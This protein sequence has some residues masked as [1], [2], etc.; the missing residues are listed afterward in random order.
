M[1]EPAKTGFKS[2]DTFL[3]HL[4]DI[5]I[6][7]G[8]LIIGQRFEPFRDPGTP[9]EN[10]IVE[11]QA[12]KQLAATSI[13][14]SFSSVQ[15]FFNLFGSFGIVERIVRE[16]EA[17]AK[18]LSSEDNLKSGILR[19]RAYE[20]AA[21]IKEKAL[22]TGDYFHVTMLDSAG[23][24][25]GLRA[26][27][28]AEIDDST[29]SAWQACLGAAFEEVFADSLPSM[30]SFET[31][32]DAYLRADPEVLARP[33]GSFSDFFNESGF[34]EFV[35][36][37][38]IFV[39][40]KFGT[41]EEEMGNLLREV[42]SD[43]GMLPEDDFSAE[44]GELDLSVDSN[45]LEAFLLDALWRRL[46][47]DKA[48]GEALDRLLVDASISGRPAAAIASLRK[49]G[50]EFGKA[51]IQ[52]MD[53][54]RFLKATRVNTVR[55]ELLTIYGSF[56]GW[57][58]RALYMPSP[59][60][61][62]AKDAM[63]RGLLAMRDLVQ[64]IYRLNLSVQAESESPAGF[65][66]DYKALLP[67]ALS[68][69][70]SLETMSRRSVGRPRGRRTREMDGSPMPKHIYELE[71]TV[72]DTEPPVYRK[73]SVPGNRTLA[74]L[75]GCVQDAFGWS[76]SHLHEFYVGDT[77]YGEPS[78]E[79]FKQVIPENTV[80]LDDLRLRK[81]SSFG[82]VYDF[83]DDWR[84]TLRVSAKIKPENGAPVPMCMEGARAAPPEDCGGS[85]GYEELLKCIATP[86]AQRT[87]EQREFIV[88][89]GKWTPDKFNID[90]VNRK[91]AKR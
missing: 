14:L 29:K 70:S 10:M 9:T 60:D 81:G 24:R 91:L 64:L 8:I 22:K 4:S 37:R 65:E 2:G 51:Y 43:P 34:L 58:R 32:R 31:V 68:A 44:A 79:D 54:S 38:D 48:I 41:T 25:F 1:N 69:L 23:T 50:A 11:D 67:Q 62:E 28:Q 72:E 45:D 77:N 26:L 35:R 47:D 5:E 84:H 49:R 61:T 87:E 6:R 90:A 40:W 73:L 82:Y 55:S 19:V 52:S 88:W 3:I 27:P 56:L 83:G 39:M 57:M 85:P 78:E 18:V 15:R 86:A 7:K 74:D 30:D 71:I 80:S 59:S 75:H 33:G 12:G 36:W 89:K 13:A 63:E 42:F 76:D 20:C 53:R 17:N 16:D 21:L 46:A 66:G